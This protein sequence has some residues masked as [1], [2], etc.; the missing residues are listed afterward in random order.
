MSLLL[1]HGFAFFSGSSS[2]YGLSKILVA[3]YYIIRGY[4]RIIGKMPYYHYTFISLT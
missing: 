4:P 3:H 2:H 1:L